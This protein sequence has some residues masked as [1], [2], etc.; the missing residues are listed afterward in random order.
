M[1]DDENLK[2]L[3]I[4]KVFIAKKLNF[5]TPNLSQMMSYTSKN[6]TNVFREVWRYF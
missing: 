2:N 1:E 5:L 6:I 3:Q 4:L